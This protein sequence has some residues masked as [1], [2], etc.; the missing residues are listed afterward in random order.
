[1]DMILCLTRR[2][3]LIHAASI[4]LVVLAANGVSAET[5][6][7]KNLLD[8]VKCLDGS[9]AL[10]FISDEE[11][12]KTSKYVVWLEG[13]GACRNMSDCELRAK[14]KLGSSTPWPNEML[15]P[16]DILKTDLSVNPDFA[17][18]VHI[19]VPYCSGDIWVGQAKEALNP[20]IDSTESNLSQ[21]VGYFQG[22]MIIEQLLD[23]VIGDA[24][25]DELIL[26]GC[27]AGGMGTFY[28]CDY[29]AAKFNESK[30]RCRPEAGYFGLPIATYPSFTAG[31]KEKPAQMHHLG[32]GWSFS[33]NPWSLESPES[34]A[35]QAASS[36]PTDDCPAMQKGINV[37]CALPPYIYP[38][39]QTPM[40]VSENTADAYQVFEQGQC[41]RSKTEKTKEYIDYLR[42]ILVSSMNKVI[43]RGSK[44]SQDGVFAPACLRHCMYWTAEEN[45]AATIRGKS[46]QQAFGDWY[47][48]R[49]S[50]GSFM[51]LNNSS[52]PR[53][54]LSCM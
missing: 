11:L 44:R 31:T 19:F 49:G 43:V 4:L 16:E 52:D 28:N 46:L 39:I 12:A 13:G 51:Y 35:C 42:N 10:Y 29:V 3:G 45:M 18:F 27:S 38:Y 34:K 32:S 20:F 23:Q 54:L 24:V 15:P 33:I 2:R 7:T 5:K 41:P 48:E 14:S 8:G 47:Y 53:Q 22:H 9:P 37:C 30:V 17:G 6:M 40:F 36:S 21:W 25:V 50:P 26:T 1:M